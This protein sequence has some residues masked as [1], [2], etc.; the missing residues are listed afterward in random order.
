MMSFIHLSVR[1]IGLCRFLNEQIALG[2]TT[3]VVRDLKLASRR[4]TPIC[5][6]KDTISPQ[7]LHVTSRLAV[8]Y[9]LNKYS[10][11]QWQ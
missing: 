1:P 2:H 5:I 4:Q 9:S 7:L 6:H 8:K 10:G 11:G 3:A